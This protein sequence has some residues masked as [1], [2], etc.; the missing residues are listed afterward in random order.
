MCTWG[1]CGSAHPRG[2]FRQACL[3]KATAQHHTSIHLLPQLDTGL[4][5][6]CIASRQALPPTLPSAT[7]S[8]RPQACT[9]R[10]VPAGSPTPPYSLGSQAYSHAWTSV[11]SYHV[12]PSPQMGQTVLKTY[13]L[14][15]CM[16]LCE[17]ACNCTEQSTLMYSI[18]GD[19]NPDF[20]KCPL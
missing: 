15:T 19:F 2:H 12:P 9:W 17:H 7:Y 16:K 3:F 6:C 11:T 18:N 8:A 20:G 1:S 14:H 5:V 13:R 4:Y 10:A